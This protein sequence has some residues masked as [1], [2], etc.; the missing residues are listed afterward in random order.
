ML[1]RYTFWLWAAVIFQLLTAVLH[2]LSL[3]VRPEPANETERQLL[4]LQ[5]TCKMDAGGGFQPTFSN[6]FTAQLL[7]FVC[8]SA[9]RA[10]QCLFAAEKGRRAS[11]EGNYRDKRSCFW[12]GFC[13]DDGVHFR[14]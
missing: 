13:G 4:M 10:D 7:F 8:L 9:W 1:K 6:L 11:C 2:S 5:T 12:C 14:R 3:F